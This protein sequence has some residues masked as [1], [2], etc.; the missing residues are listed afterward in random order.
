M[1]LSLESNNVRLP[2][3]DSSEHVWPDFGRT[4]PDPVG[5]RPF[6]PNPTGS[7]PFWP[8]L[9]G[10]VAGSIKIRPDSGQF[11]QIRPTSDHGRLP[12]RFGRNLVRQYPATVARCC[13][14]PVPPGFRRPTIARFRQSNIK[15]ACKDEEFNFEK[16]FTVLKIVNRFPKIKEGFTVKPK[17]IFV[18]HYFL[19]YQTP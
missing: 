15:C 19:P 10:T 14:I 18:D 6:W 7:R 17:M 9:V 3:P 16:R 13:R 12:A 11:G 8:D 2:L 4:P 1:Q 5:S